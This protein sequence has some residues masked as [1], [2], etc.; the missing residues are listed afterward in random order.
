MLARTIS[1]LLVLTILGSAPPPRSVAGGGSESDVHTQVLRSRPIR[2]THIK[3]V[4]S[5]ESAGPHKVTL[6]VVRALKPGEDGP[7]YNGAT[8]S[9]DSKAITSSTRYGALYVTPSFKGVLFNGNLAVTKREFTGLSVMVLSPDSDDSTIFSKNGQYIVDDG[10]FICR[11]TAAVDV[12]YGALG[13][14]AFLG[15]G[16]E[17]EWSEGL[18]YRTTNQQCYGKVELGTDE[19]GNRIG[20]PLSDVKNY[21]ERCTGGVEGKHMKELLDQTRQR[22]QNDTTFTIKDK[23]CSTDD[24]CYNGDLRWEGRCMVKSEPKKID[25][26]DKIYYYRRCEDRIV[27]NGYCTNNMGGFMSWFGPRK[28]DA[29][30]TCTFIDKKYDWNHFRY[31]ETYKCLPTPTK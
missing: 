28:C 24:D 14:I 11:L 8:Y 26:K 30:L 15:V 16:A 29:G 21:C 19:Q 9:D 25:G 10:F 6:P 3:V 4:G 20:V 2:D 12:L 1:Y 5:S 31:N 13:G 17:K 23:T 27:K 18:N 7:A 22:A